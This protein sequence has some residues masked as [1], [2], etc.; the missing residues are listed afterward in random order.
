MFLVVQHTVRDYDA[1]K[2][3]YDEHESVR[4]QYGFLGHTIYRDA[5]KP[6]DVTTFNRFD[7]TSPFGGYKESGFGREGGIQGLGAY[8][9]K[10][11][12]R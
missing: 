2:I 5:D 6:N 10:E 1:W 12:T 7:P 8:L 3:V 11:V 9:T 4:A